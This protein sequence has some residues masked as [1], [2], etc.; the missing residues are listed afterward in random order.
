MMKKFILKIFFYAFLL[1]LI[2]NIIGFSANYFLKRSH[3]YKSSFLVNKFKE[4]KKFDYFIVG[5]SRGLTTLKSTII[6]STL[7]TKGVNLSMDDT[8]LKTQF[9]M[10]KH[11]FKSNFKADYL[12]LTL[13]AS[14]FNKTSLRLGNNDYRFVPF[15]N[16]DY[17][18]NHFKEY[19]TSS[20]KILTN[21]NFNPF[22]SYSYY[23]LELLL[24]ATLSVIKPKFR[25]KFD[26]FGNY[27]YPLSNKKA[28]DKLDIIKSNQKITNPLIKKID[29][30]LKL[31]NCKLIIYIAPYAASNFIFDNNFNY[32]IINHSTVLNNY[33]NVFYDKIHVNAQGSK[34]ATKLFTSNFKLLIN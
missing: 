15:I 27:S 4:N 24:P 19:E 14:H 3:F 13:D 34:L 23:N 1:L 33:D 17:V 12:I 31:N 20:L 29:K 16:K 7:H 32:E 18:R 26:E 28:I 8:D 25:N 21:S 6:D 5:S 9:L 11:F 22:F 10:I 2:A 30:Y